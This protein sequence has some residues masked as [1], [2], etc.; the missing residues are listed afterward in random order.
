LKKYAADSHLKF[1]DIDGLRIEQ[2]EGWCIVRES[3]TENLVRI[4]AESKSKQASEKI[5]SEMKKVVERILG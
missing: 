2:K 5:A 3:G 4:F 1:N